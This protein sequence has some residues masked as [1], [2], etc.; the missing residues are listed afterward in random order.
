MMTGAPLVARYLS[1]W[2]AGWALTFSPTGAK[3]PRPRDIVTYFSQPL[4][5]KR[6]VCSR[7]NSP[8]SSFRTR[9]ARRSSRYPPLSSGTSSLGLLVGVRK[10]GSGTSVGGVPRATA[11][12]A[13]TVWGRRGMFPLGSGRRRLLGIGGRAGYWEV[14]SCTIPVLIPT[15]PTTHSTVRFPAVATHCTLLAFRGWCRPLQ[16]L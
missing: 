12:M 7:I 13:S 16:L 1:R 6:A 11:R 8:S 5:R 10:T 2:L 14:T 4:L 15:R 9:I 3:S